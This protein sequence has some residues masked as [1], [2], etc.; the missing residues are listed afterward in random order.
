MVRPH[1]LV[2]NGSIRG[3]DGNTGWLVE[4][5]VRRLDDR[6]SAEIIHLA[7]LH[8]DV[9]GIVDRLRTASA[10]LV[11][12][13]VYWHAW[14]SPLQRFL[15]VVTPFENTDAFFAKPV[16]ALITMDSVGGSELCARLLGVIG[17]LGCLVPPCSSLVLGR[18][19]MEAAAVVPRRGEHDPNDDVWQLMDLDVVLHNLLAPLTGEA[20]RRWELRPLIAPRG[21]YP[22]SGRLELGSP[23]FL[24]PEPV[25]ED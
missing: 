4:E 11:G 14:G 18:V 2:L 25:S 10:F 9:D 7:D 8:D 5:A 3:A 15:E 6:A 17:S 12:T 13:G 23:R 21:A 1:V 20:Y 22:A 24:P 16:G 19:A